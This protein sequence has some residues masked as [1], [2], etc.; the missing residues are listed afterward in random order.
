MFC[1]PCL[2][3]CKGQSSQ[4]QRAEVRT[5]T[6]FQEP[7]LQGTRKLLPRPG[8]ATSLSCSGQICCKAGQP[9]LPPDH[10]CA[11]CCGCRAGH[12]WGR[13][14]GLIW[15]RCQPGEGRG[16][17]GGAVGRPRVSALRAP[18]V[19]VCLGQRSWK[20]TA[21]ELGKE[22]SGWRAGL[23]GEFGET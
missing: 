13:E 21:S 19:Y 8:R 15:P 20:N 4:P 16:L 14:E 22:R 9:D 23:R 3:L 6:P 1:D 12:S 10:R 7:V 17:Q 2:C 5:W 11:R 18:Y